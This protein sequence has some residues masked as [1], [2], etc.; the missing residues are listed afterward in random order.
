M[1]SPWKLWQPRLLVV[2]RRIL[3]LAADALPNNVMSI[4]VWVSGQL[5]CYVADAH[6]ASSSKTVFSSRISDGH[7][8]GC[9]AGYSF[10]AT[11]NGAKQTLSFYGSLS[12][13]S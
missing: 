2:Y 7:G 9:A 10:S 6:L 4:Q 11:D 1:P 12:F 3:F 13:Q 8:S 5:L